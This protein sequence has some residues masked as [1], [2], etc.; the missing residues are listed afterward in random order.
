MHI[1]GESF[2]FDISSYFKYAYY[3]EFEIKKDNIEF[4]EDDVE[5]FDFDYYN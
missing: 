2:R 3:F 1:L 4:Q 5:W